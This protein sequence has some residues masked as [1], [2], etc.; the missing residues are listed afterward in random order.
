MSN[1]TND[2]NRVTSTIITISIRIIVCALVI[3]LLYE[4]VTRG[5]AFGHAVFYEEAVEAPPGRDQTFT[6]GEG[7]T[8]NDIADRLADQGLITNKFAFVFQ[9]RFYEYDN[10]SPGTYDLNTSMTSKE[11]LQALNAAPQEEEE[12]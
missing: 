4:G 5:F 1:T 3:L 12:T 6:V 9:S 11:I 10:F 8:V 2:I 7:D